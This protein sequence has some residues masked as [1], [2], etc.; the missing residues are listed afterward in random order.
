M[1]DILNLIPDPQFQHMERW[2]TQGATVTPL[3]AQNAMN[4]VNTNGGT[5]SFA[6]LVLQDVSDYRG[7][8]MTVACSLS[9]IADDATQ[10]NNGLLWVSAD[11][12][13]EYIWSARDD[14]DATVGRKVLQFTLP[15]DTTTLGIRI[16]APATKDSLFQWRRPILTRTKDYQRLLN[17]SA[18][19]AAVDYFDGD[20]RP[21]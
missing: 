21:E 8:G 9:A 6:E 12:R 16:Y 5:D 18:T 1:T 14:G 4:V 3:L 17:G 7:V 19:G 10:C 13:Q 20:T 11:H 15:D 2:K